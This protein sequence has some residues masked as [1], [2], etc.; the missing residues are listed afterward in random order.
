L[1]LTLIKNLILMVVCGSVLC[2]LA[3]LLGYSS[4]LPSILLG[5]ATGIVYFILL[6]QQVNKGGRMEPE[7][8]I[9]YMK[10]GWLQRFCLVLSVVIIAIKLNWEVLPLLAGFYTYRVV[11][12]ID[13][14]VLTIREFKKD[15]EAARA[16][17]VTYIT[18]PGQLEK[19][20]KVCQRK[21]SSF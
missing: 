9:Q 16:A 11:L 19:E 7:R 12:Y 18:P 8:A 10:G 13:T 3:V 21:L 2:I 6:Y 1:G 4:K 14:I 5:I 17:K 15:E 20:G